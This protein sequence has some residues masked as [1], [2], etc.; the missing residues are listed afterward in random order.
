MVVL[1]VQ[2]TAG[3]V[4]AGDIGLRAVIAVLYS[5]IAVCRKVL[6]VAEAFNI[7]ACVVHPDGIR[8]GCRQRCGGEQREQHHKA[9]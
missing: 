7:A 1:E 3:L 2:R 8:I 6:L 5:G 9:E 4:V